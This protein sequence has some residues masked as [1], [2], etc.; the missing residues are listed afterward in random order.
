MTGERG[1]ITRTVE[2]DDNGD[3]VVH[4]RGISLEGRD[5]AWKYTV[6]SRF[7][8]PADTA[9]LRRLCEST[10]E[11]MRRARLMA[12]DVLNPERN[13]RLDAILDQLN[14]ERDRLGDMMTVLEVA[15]A[16]EDEGV[17]DG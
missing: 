15:Q 6:D 4:S 11:L 1:E 5:L 17:T 3:F 7:L 8:S 13:D 16:T 10:E 2:V 14:T 9:E 12:A